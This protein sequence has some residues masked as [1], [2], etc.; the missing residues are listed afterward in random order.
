MR[1]SSGEDKETSFFFQRI[2]V[3]IQRFKFCAFARLFRQGRS[4]PIA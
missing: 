1:A 3:L 2:S 4:G